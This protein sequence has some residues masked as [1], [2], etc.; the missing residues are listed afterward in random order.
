M[1]LPYSLSTKTWLIA[2][3]A[4]PFIIVLPIIAVLAKGALEIATFSAIWLLPYTLMLPF[5]YKRYHQLPYVQ[6][7]KE[8]WQLPIHHARLYSGASVLAGLIAIAVSFAT[9]PR[10]NT[11]EMLFN[12]SMGFI[13]VL[14]LGA[15][16]FAISFIL[17]YAFAGLFMLIQQIL[18]NSHA[19]VVKDTNA[20]PSL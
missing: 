11:L 5:W 3:L 8:A 4:W 1:A 17:G 7:K 10:L 2:G 16:V 9:D 19:I 13:S 15:L 20:N 18:E 14:F 12:L 6:L